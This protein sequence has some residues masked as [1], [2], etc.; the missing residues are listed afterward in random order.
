MEK[1]HFSHKPR[2]VGNPN[3]ISV[4][5]QLEAA[6]A[7]VFAVLRGTDKH[8]DE[9]VVERVIELALESPFELRVVEVARMQ[10]EV[11]G[12]DGNGFVLELND[13]LDAF[14]FGAGVEGQ[15]RMFVEAELGKDA[16]KARIAGARHGNIVQICEA[17]MPDGNLPD[18]TDVFRHHGLT[19]FTAEGFAELR[20][21]LHHTIHAEL[22]WR[23]RIGLYLEP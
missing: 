23:M 9:V 2:E 15:E 22:A 19:A 18:S 4:S 6:F 14:A 13:D 11:V 8:F 1:P 5:Q 21:V 10:V 12:V 17:A 7:A 16:V 3:V 20:H